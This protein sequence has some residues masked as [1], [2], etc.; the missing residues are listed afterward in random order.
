MIYLDSSAL[1]KLVLP[2]AESTALS[3][4]LSERTG[5]VRASSALVRVEV[6]RAINS[7]DC[8]QV[9]RTRTLIDAMALVPMTN[10]LLD[11]AGTLQHGLRSLDAIHVASALRL[12]GDLEVFVAYDQRLLEAAEEAGL[13][14]ASPG[15]P[16]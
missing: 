9:S 15:K 8:A 11:E 2:E 4:W 5:T 6:V 12:R 14:V 16:R 10:D 3:Q 1:V 7:R 13:W